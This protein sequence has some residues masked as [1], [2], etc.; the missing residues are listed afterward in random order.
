ML[1]GKLIVES[2]EA[3]INRM[4]VINSAS[5]E[6]TNAGI[7]AMLCRIEAISSASNKETNAG[8]EAMLCRIEASIEAMTCKHVESQAYDQHHKVATIDADIEAQNV[9]GVVN[10]GNR[11]PSI[12]LFGDHGNCDDG[13]VGLDKEEFDL[14]KYPST[15]QE[16]LELVQRKIQ[17]SDTTADT[18]TSMNQQKVLSTYMEKMEFVLRGQR[19]IQGLDTTVDTITPMEL[20]KVESEDELSNKFYSTLT[21]S[22][23]LG[24]G[25]TGR[26]IPMNNKEVESG[27]EYDE[28]WWESYMAGENPDM[29]NLPIP[30]FAENNLGRKKIAQAA[31][32]ES[33]SESGDGDQDCWDEIVQ[34]TDQVLEANPNTSYIE[35][36]LDY[37]FAQA[38]EDGDRD[39][40]K[41]LY[42][43]YPDLVD[44]VI[45]INSETALLLAAR[46]ERWMLVEEIVELMSPEILE[47]QDKSFGN[48]GLHYAAAYGKVKAVK[49]MAKKCPKLAQTRNSEGRVPLELAVYA[50][51]VGQL[52]TVAYLYSVTPNEHPSPFSGPEGAGLLCT[53]IQANMYEMALSLVKRFPNLVTMPYLKPK[54]LRSGICGLEMMIERPFTFLSGAHLTWWERCIY[55]LIEVDMASLFDEMSFEDL[56]Q[57]GK[58]SWK[59]SIGDEENPKESQ[60]PL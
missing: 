15:Y 14:S 40:I 33:G 54:R 44:R 18:I 23:G 25:A 39:K 49:L 43:I 42:K 29:I 52:E 34:I 36:S 2:Q 3:M 27:D 56:N 50:L 13:Q 24:F 59:V 8:I 7:E 30:T 12:L 21:D 60:L 26:T 38:A 35:I 20:Q 46:N 4:E 9:P 53:P 11:S 32:A 31:E 41:E 58:N 45:N 17:G 48:T 10:S 57:A 1:F 22:R 55:S 6:A 28:K 37:P 19:K 47:L 5:I 51:T 16:M